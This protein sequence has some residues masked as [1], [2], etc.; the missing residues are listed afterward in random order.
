M[1]PF[2]LYH[3]EPHCGHVSL[4]VVMLSPPPLSSLLAQGPEYHKP[5]KSITRRALP[6]RKRRLLCLKP[7][8]LCHPCGVMAVALSPGDDRAVVWDISAGGLWALF[9][10]STGC[11]RS[12][13]VSG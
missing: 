7:R 2:F 1:C 6:G 13:A 5:F 10:V 3:L 8:R 11:S 9:V 12:C 4:G